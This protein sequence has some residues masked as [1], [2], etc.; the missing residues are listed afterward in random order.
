MT[1]AIQ[2]VSAADVEAAVTAR[3]RPFSYVAIERL[4][5]GFTVQFSR[6]YDKEGN[7]D[8]TTYYAPDKPSIVA[9]IEEHLI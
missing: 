7:N 2:F 6:T 1:D 3:L 9:L 5:N 8:A 4:Q